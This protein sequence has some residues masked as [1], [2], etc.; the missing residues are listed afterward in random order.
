MGSGYSSPSISQMAHPDG[1]SSWSTTSSDYTVTDHTPLPSI[2]NPNMSTSNFSLYN[3]LPHQWQTHAV[4]Q[5]A[6]PGSIMQPHS[7]HGEQIGYPSS[8]LLS[9]LWVNDDGV[10]RC[11][12]TGPLEELKLHC[13]AMHFTPGPNAAQIE[14]RWQDCDYYK[15]ND[16]TVRVMRHDSIW[17]HIYGVHLGLKRGS[18]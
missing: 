16:P 4:P 9:C 11:R 10:T 5:P 6:H 17:R 2:F 15:R 7:S 1:Y 8:P 14:C 12:F 3:T 13:K 18:I